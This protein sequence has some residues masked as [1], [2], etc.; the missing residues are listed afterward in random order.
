MADKLQLTLQCQRTSTKSLKATLQVRHYGN[1]AFL[2]KCTNFLLSAGRGESSDSDSDDS[3]ESISDSDDE[4]NKAENGDE[5][6]NENEDD[7][8]E[9]ND[10]SDEDDDDEDSDDEDDSDEDEADNGKKQPQ[11]CMSSYALRSMSSVLMYC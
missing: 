11:R 5:G 1:Y 7:D 6:M 8:A 2:G 4:E 10:A 3:S 9:M